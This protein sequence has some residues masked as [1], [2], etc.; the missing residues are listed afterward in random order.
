MESLNESVSVRFLSPGDRDAEVSRLDLPWIAD[1]G[2]LDVAVR[3]GS[4]ERPLRFR[5]LAF[6][7]VSTVVW[8]EDAVQV[9]RAAEPEPDVIALKSPVLVRERFEQPIGLTRIDYLRHG[10]LIGSRYTFQGGLHA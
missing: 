5:G 6:D 7:E 3:R 10:V 8:D 1:E 2:P 9:I 4:D